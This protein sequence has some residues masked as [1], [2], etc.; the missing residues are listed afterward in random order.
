MFGFDS[1]RNE[2][3]AKKWKTGEVEG[4]EGN[5][6][7]QTP[8]FWKSAFEQYWHVSIKGLFHTERSCVERDTHLSCGCCLFWLAS[9][10][11]TD[12]LFSLQSPSS[13]GDKIWAAGNLCDRQRKGVVVGEEE[14]ILL[15]SFFFLS[16]AQRSAL[17]LARSPM[18]SKR[19]KRKIK[20]RLCKG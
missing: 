9:S 20:Q 17:V 12:P 8:R 18:F 16:R 7:R 14:N 10:V 13:S 3:R 15:S 4:K 6:C 19:T 1:A 2:T 5:P 11:V